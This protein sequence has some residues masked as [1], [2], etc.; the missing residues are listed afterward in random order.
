MDT[1]QS[2]EA[3]KDVAVL[4]DDMTTCIRSASDK[5]AVV[6]SLL[7]NSKHSSCPTPFC[8]LLSPHFSC[9]LQSIFSLPRSPP[10]SPPPSSSRSL[11][12]MQAF[13]VATFLAH[14]PKQ[15]ILAAAKLSKRTRDYGSAGFL[16]VMGEKQAGWVGY[17]DNMQA[18]SLQRR[19]R[20]VPS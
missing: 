2:E 5:D 16:N 7:C 20:G 10:L 13:C 6:R 3:P 18:H 9:S 12:D 14:A 4:V 11:K 15:T 8:F 19:Q 1:P 17:E